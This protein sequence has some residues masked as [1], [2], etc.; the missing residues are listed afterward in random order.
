MPL[1]LQVSGLSRERLGW[2]LGIATA[3]A[4]LVQPVLGKLSDRLDARRP[5]MVGAAL[6]AWG[7]YTALGKVSGFWPFLGLIVLGSNGFTYLNQ[8]GGVLVGRIVSA[9][10]GGA[11]YARYRVWGS[12]GYV[13]V[14]LVTGFLLSPKPGMAR[15][16]LAPIFVF[17][18]LL[19]LAV[20]VLALFVPDPKRAPDA[21]ITADATRRRRSYRERPRPTC[22]GFCWRSRSTPSRSTG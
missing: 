14:T 21:P 17:G 11:G 6:L 1:F 2:V 3:T 16:D 5:L 13:V 9:E 19:Y 22:G 18:P 15:A 4:L 12:V 20:A 8:V 10:S 7:A